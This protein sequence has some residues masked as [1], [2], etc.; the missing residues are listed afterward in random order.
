MIIS[1][2]LNVYL[3]T[4]ETCNLNCSHCF[5]SGSKG[6]RIFFDPEKLIDFFERLALSCPWITNV[7]FLF[8]GGEP[9][10]APIEN[11]YQFYHGAKNIF[12]TTRFG[13]QT[14]LVYPLGDKYREFFKEVLLEDGFGTSWDYDIR[15]GSTAKDNHS[16]DALREKQQKIWEKNVGKLVSDS[17]Y[18]TMI[19]SIT[20]KLIQ[21]KEPIEII[22][23]AKDLGFKHILFERITSDGNA[24][25]N[26]QIIPTNREQDEWLY[27][28]FTQTIAHESYKE[29]G[30]MFLSELAEAYV[31]HK[32]GGNRCRVCEKSLLTIN[33]DG[34]IAGCPNSAPSSAW[35]NIEWDIS[36]NLNS[37]K[38]LKAISCEVF[39][40]DAKCYECKAFEYCNSDCQKLSWDE[41]GEYCA[42]PKQIWTHMIEK[43]EIEVYKKI[44]LGLPGGAAHGV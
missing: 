13:M 42:A 14:N 38:R 41:E 3:K 22:N 44:I 5:T 8:H 2:E 11:L 33:A 16:R 6:A 30:N 35:G 15:F 43:N 39:S 37:K 4:T 10:L 34:T 24:K 18:L 9:M 25:E 21:E 20:K 1:P 17:H 7:K 26:S 32:H 40:R 23:Y 28:M 27:R 29:I 36:T 12:K 19:V 31:F